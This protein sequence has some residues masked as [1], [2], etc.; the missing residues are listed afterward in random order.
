MTMTDPIADFLTRIRNGYQARKKIVEVPYSK[1]KERIG[2]ILVK[3]GYLK[4]M[5]AKR[6]KTQEKKLVLALKYKGREPSVTG[7]KRVSK[8][9]VRVYARAGKIP[10]SPWGFGVTVLSTS[11]GLVTDKEARKK[12]IGGEVVCQIW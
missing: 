1:I 2:Q 11:Q 10:K 12:K 9:G 6:G 8:P 7:I 4:E 5:E 3:E